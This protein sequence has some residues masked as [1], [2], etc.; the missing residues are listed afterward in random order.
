MKP[1]KIVALVLIPIVAVVIA[2]G[3]AFTFY[4][5]NLLNSAN[6]NGPPC[7]SSPVSTLSQVQFTIMISS[8]GLNS[9]GT[10]SSCPILNVAKGQSVTIHFV[11]NDRE[12]HRIAIATY[13]GNGISLS[14]G[15]SRDIMFTANQTG[16]F[17]I[18]CNVGCAA[19]HFMQNGRLNVTS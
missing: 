7:A 10:S 4:Y 14:P 8:Q 9:S 17:Q 19:H 1:Y 2:A 5:P 3:A 13:L 11:N 6:L 12:T 16:N 18:Y 15:E